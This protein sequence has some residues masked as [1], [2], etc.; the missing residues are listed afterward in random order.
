MRNG[1]LREYVKAQDSG[2][3]TPKVTQSSHRSS[4]VA[5]DSDDEEPIN[6]IDSV[7]AMGDFGSTS[8]GKAPTLVCLATAPEEALQDWGPITFST[9]DTVGV[10]Y[11]H[12]DALIISM[13]VGTRTVKR[14]LID[15]GSSLDIIHW[16]PLQKLGYTLQ[17]LQASRY[18]IRGIG[19]HRTRPVG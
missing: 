11:P 1:K 9:T 3:K 12:C 19:G 18:C 15:H 2:E 4:A 16:D 8:S 14:T 10:R 5:Q 7:P 6:Y 13:Q 17:Q